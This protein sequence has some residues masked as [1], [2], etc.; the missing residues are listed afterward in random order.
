AGLRQ[1]A[2]SRGRRRGEA[3]VRAA[4]ASVQ[5]AFVCSRRLSART[6]SPS[7][8]TAASGARA[9]KGREVQ[10]LDAGWGTAHACRPQRRPETLGHELLLLC[11]GVPD[12]EHDPAT[13]LR[14]AG[15]EANPR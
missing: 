15:M 9:P 13:G 5:T 12:L 8:G 1:L 6:A 3:G 10:P 14:A 7:V 2:R 4:D 11:A